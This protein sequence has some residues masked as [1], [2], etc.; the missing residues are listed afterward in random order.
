[1]RMSICSRS[2]CRSFKSWSAV[3]FSPWNMGIIWIV[4]CIV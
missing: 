4:L 3:M 2:L 1:M